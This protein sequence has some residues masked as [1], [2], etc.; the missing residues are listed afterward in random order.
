ML[1]HS[2][3]L[4]KVHMYVGMYTPFSFFFLLEKI[5]QQTRKEA[6]MATVMAK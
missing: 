3:A 4:L 5:T 1:K 2:Q 6:D